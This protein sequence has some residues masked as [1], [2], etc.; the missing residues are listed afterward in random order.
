MTQDGHETAP[1]GPTA[2]AAYHCRVVTENDQVTP[3]QE[4]TPFFERPVHCDHFFD[5]YMFI[6]LT[7]EYPCR[8]ELSNLVVSWFAR[9]IPG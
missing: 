2:Q 1:C 4:G 5:V 9:A 8:E 6:P 7:K 3:R